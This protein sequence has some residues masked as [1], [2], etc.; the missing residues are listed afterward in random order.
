[1][2]TRNKSVDKTGDGNPLVT[3]YITNYNY[4]QYLRTAI[5]SVF[6]QN[7]QDF[8]LI[9][10]DDGSTDNSREIIRE[11][12]DHPQ[13][14]I[15]FQE[16]RGLNQSIDVAI[17]AARGN[18]VM[19]L[20]ADDFLDPNALLVLTRELEADED[21]AL[22]FP[23]YYYVNENDEVIGQ[24]HRHDFSDVTVP[25]RPA[26]GACTLFRKRV[27]KEVGSYS[28]DYTCQDGYDIWVKI[29]NKYSVK[30]V[31]LPLFYY[32]QHGKNLTENNKKILE[33]RTEIKTDYVKENGEM[34][35]TVGII[36]VRGEI[37]DPESPMLEK[38]GDKPVI[39]WTLEAVDKTP[40]IEKSIVSTPDPDVLEYIKNRDGKIETHE[41]DIELA[42]E[43]VP[44]DSTLKA[45]CEELD[46][47][48]FDAIAQLTPNSPFRTNRIIEEGITTLEIFPVD[49]V[50]GVLPE[51]DQFY[52]HDGNGLQPVGG[53]FP[54]Q[55]LRLERERLFRR[56][57][58]LKIMNM[59]FF[60]DEERG[61]N[62]RLG[63]VILQEQEAININNKENVNSI[64]RSVDLE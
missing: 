19:R 37:I 34:P 63:H 9:I 25:D 28:T 46:T 49:E 17:K 6:D 42:R 43:N 50:V 4:D 55:D 40:Q 64:E 30:N 3:V 1:M 12:A 33:T 11:Y 5:E 29:I 27:L 58:G 57:G 23:D 45:V 14:R 35:S 60:L 20:D 7:F 2:K 10:I 18:Y 41:R 52:I 8:E 21:A 56:A 44:L 53:M 13:T 51:E 38:L 54:E 62:P 59:D 47:S 48:S 31:N 24:E 36:P 32:R 22:V 16:N 26:H 61:H 15:I 39:E